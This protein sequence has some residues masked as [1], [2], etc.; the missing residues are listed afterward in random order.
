MIKR[1]TQ[2]LA[3]CLRALHRDEN[4]A[5]MV[6]YVLVIAAIALPILAVAIYFKDQIWT[7]VSEQ[8][9]QIKSDSSNNPLQ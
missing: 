2:K 6:E 8:F 1:S 4:G 5:D 3:R 7:W 9:Q